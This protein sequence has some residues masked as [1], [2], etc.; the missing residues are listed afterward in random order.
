MEHHTRIVGKNITMVYIGVGAILMYGKY[1]C[2]ATGP[3]KCGSKLYINWFLIST[4][5][6]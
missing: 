1:T 2:S 4:L 3:I 6:T 5:L